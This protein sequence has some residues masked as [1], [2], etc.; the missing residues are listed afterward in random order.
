MRTLALG[1][2]VLALAGVPALAQG[3]GP[4]PAG[5]EPIAPLEI[6]RTPIRSATVEPGC[7]FGVLSVSA[8]ARLPDRSDAA[9][10]L[11][12]FGRCRVTAGVQLR[13]A[14]PFVVNRWHSNFESTN[15]SE[16]GSPSLELRLQ[17]VRLQGIRLAAYL[18]ATVNWQQRPSVVTETEIT[19]LA[20]PGFA[21]STI[22]RGIS[23]HANAEANLPFGARNSRSTF[24][25]GLALAYQPRPGVSMHAGYQNAIDLLEDRYWADARVFVLGAR[26]RLSRGWAGELGTRIAV[27]PEAE[28]EFNSLSRVATLINFIYEV[29]AR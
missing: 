18:A 22:Y 23:V 26:I 16:W 12:F 11:G 20:E 24:L 8:R 6:L 17:L 21:A 10:Q 7:G 4:E 15:H 25:I 14:M 9:G 3:R 27:N 5:R 1:V 19:G 29:R 28:L 2:V 13:A